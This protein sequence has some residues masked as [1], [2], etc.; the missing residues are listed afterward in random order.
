MKLQPV[1]QPIRR[2]V[3]QRQEEEDHIAVNFLK[4]LKFQKLN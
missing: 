1:V 3:K 2:R 4:N